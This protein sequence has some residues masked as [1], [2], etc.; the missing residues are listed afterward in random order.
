[1]KQ[2]SYLLEI[3]IWGMLLVPLTYLFISWPELPD[4]VPIHFNYKGEADG[5]GSKNFLAGLIVFITAGMNLL[6]LLIPA[7][8]PKAKISSMGSKYHQLRFMLAL[9]MGALS[10]LIVYSAKVG[11]LEDTNFINLL[12]GFLFLSFGNYFQAIR[13]NYFIGIRTPWTLES[14]NVWRKTHRLGGKIW[15]AAGV[16]ICLTALLPDAATRITVFLTIAAI[17]VLIP[18]VYSFILSRKEQQAVQ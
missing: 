17:A 2:K 16:L 13:P 7:I 10:V 11:N 3:L 12:V 5:W 9:F 15:I 14:E 8:D 1:M 18:V 4:R 6:L